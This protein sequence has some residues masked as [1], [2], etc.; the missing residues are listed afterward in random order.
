MFSLGLYQHFKGRYFYVDNI[1]R[2][3]DGEYMVEYFDIFHPEA[4]KFV[5]EY[6]DFLSKETVDKKT[7]EVIQ[8]LDREDNVTHQ[9]IRFRKVSN[10]GLNSLKDY[11]TMELVKELGRRV[12]SPYQNLGIEGLSDKVYAIDYCIGRE[13][14]STV[15]FGEEV[16]NQVEERESFI[17]KY[18]ALK[19]LR[20]NYALQDSVKVFKR[21]FIEED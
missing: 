18:E 21:T 4:G 5:R 9:N 14:P 2:N 17:Y 15:S 7:G 12:D 11:T 8:I 20:E 19:Y 1:V 13:V 3:E 10:F 16:P 6:N